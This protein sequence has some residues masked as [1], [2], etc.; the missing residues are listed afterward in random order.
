M[1]IQQEKPFL[2]R[3]FLGQM[4]IRRSQSKTLHRNR[5]F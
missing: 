1:V 3:R 2:K 4:P 5:A